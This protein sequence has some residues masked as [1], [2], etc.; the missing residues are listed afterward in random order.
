M[1]GLKQLIIFTIFISTKLFA[2]APLEWP[3]SPTVVG[4]SAATTYPNLCAGES[5]TAV[6]AW[7]EAGANNT[8]W[9]SIYDPLTGTWG[10]QKQISSLGLSTGL[11]Q[12]D[13]PVLCCLPSGDFIAAWTEGTAIGVS[14]YHAIAKLWSTPI[15]VSSGGTNSKPA[16][17]CNSSGSAILVWETNAGEIHFVTFDGSGWSTSAVAATGSTYFNPDV[18]MDEAGNAILVGVDG[19]ANRV[20]HAY[21]NGAGWTSPS[22]FTG[23]ASFGTYPVVTCN[24][25]GAAIV[26]WDN[27]IALPRKGQAATTTDGVNWSA[28]H[29]FSPGTV[30]NL[31]TFYVDACINEEGNGHV[32][33]FTGVTDSTPP[34]GVLASYYDG[35]SQTFSPVMPISEALDEYSQG[36]PPRVCCSSCGNATALWAA[37]DNTNTPVIQTATFSG[38]TLE[39][40]ALGVTIQTLAG[41]PLNAPTRAYPALQCDHFGNAFAIWR[42]DVNNR[43]LNMNGYCTESP[44][45][46]WL[47][48]RENRFPFQ[49]ER[50]YS[51]HWSVE[52]CIR[53]I[54]GYQVYINGVLVA[55]V[56]GNSY[57]SIPGSARTITIRP[58]NALGIPGAGQTIQV[59]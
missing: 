9:A 18:C 46:V 15:H 26:A 55:M 39:W 11:N 33:M 45:N 34:Y 42:D 38:A 3:A 36:W 43:I 4:G 20:F 19:N 24:G 53:G 47:K 52:P 51:V 29:D 31:Q 14:Y 21:F 35:A 27:A 32:V 50:Y 28:V 57:S 17:S 56:T 23:I 40:G 30:G 49:T 59:N 37:A 12:E 13:Q 10:P 48:E 54:V 25:S 5:G 1:K 44:L 22:T 6:S 2:C 41:T 58:V 7:I 16:L 8:V